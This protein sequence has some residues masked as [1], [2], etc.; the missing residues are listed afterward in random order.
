M[1]RP[2]S[3]GN[4]CFGIIDTFSK[5]NQLAI[6]FFSNFVTSLKLFGREKLKLQCTSPF[7]NVTCLISLITCLIDKLFPIQL[8]DIGKQSRL[9]TFFIRFENTFFVEES[10]ATQTYDMIHLGNYFNF[11]NFFNNNSSLFSFHLHHQMKLKLHLIF[12]PNA[13]VILSFF[14]GKCLFF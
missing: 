2:V 4:C 6:R 12:F 14:F 8:D 7:D 5:K 13:C 1:G 10:L 3:L 11:C 9:N